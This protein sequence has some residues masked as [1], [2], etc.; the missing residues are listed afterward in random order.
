MDIKVL[1][2]CIIKKRRKISEN[3]NNGEGVDFEMKADDQDYTNKFVFAG[4]NTA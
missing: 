1:P 4:N 2:K 3:L